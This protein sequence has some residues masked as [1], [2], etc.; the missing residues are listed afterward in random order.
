MASAVSEDRSAASDGGA[1]NFRPDGASLVMTAR[2]IVPAGA[3]RHRLWVAMSGFVLALLLIPFSYKAS[4]RLETASHI[5]GGEA[6]VVER[7]LAQR[8]QSPYAHRLIAAIKGLPDPESVEGTNALDLIADR[9][10]S[11]PRVSGVLSS[12]IG[13]IRC[14]WARMAEHW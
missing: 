7:E 3:A 4:G 1:N 14:F 11:H 10:R 6:E 2:H 8:F 12:S 9:L 5:K 13:L